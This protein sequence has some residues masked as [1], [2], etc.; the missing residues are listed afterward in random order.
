[1]KAE[2]KQTIQELKEVINEEK[3]NILD[4]DL[5]EFALKLYITESINKSKDYPK[6]FNSFNKIAGR[7]PNTRTNAYTSKEEPPTQKQIDACK[8]KGITIPA[9]ATKK[10]VW[11]IMNSRD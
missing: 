4:K 7:V 2:L 3:L 5:L 9:G 10:D 6:T 8:R 11:K 1:M